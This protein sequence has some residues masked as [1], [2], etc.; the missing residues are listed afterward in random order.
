[1]FYEI[2]SHDARLIHSLAEELGRQM[3]DDLWRLYRQVELPVAAILNEM[4]LSRG[5]LVD[6]WACLDELEKAEKE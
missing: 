1:M 2:L 5:L 4:S 6:R 3:D